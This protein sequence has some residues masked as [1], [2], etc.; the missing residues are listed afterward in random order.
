MTEPK[1]MA[2]SS[3][4]EGQVGGWEKV[5]YYRMVGMEQ[6]AQGNGHSPKQ[7]EFKEH[8]SVL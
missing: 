5:L 4:A 8:L 6:T 3:M 2:L 7:L 1:G